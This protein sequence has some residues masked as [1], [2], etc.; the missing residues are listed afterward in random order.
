M[1][2]AWLGS[3][4]MAEVGEA[5]SVVSE[6]CIQELLEVFSRGAYKARNAL[7]RRNEVIHK[8]CI[9][10]IARDYDVEV[11]D[12]KSGQLCGHYPSE[13]IVIERH[14]TFA[15]TTSSATRGRGHPV[16]D[17]AKLK[18]LIST[19]RYA[20]CRLRFVMPVILFE[21]K[22]VCRSATLSTMAEMY[23]RAGMDWFTVQCIRIQVETQHHHH[24]YHQVVVEEVVRT[25]AGQVSFS[26]LLLLITIDLWQWPWAGGQGGSTNTRFSCILRE[27]MT[28]VRGQ[29]VQLLKA[30][31]VDLICDLMVEKKKSKYGLLVASSEKVDKWARYCDFQIASM[32]YPGCEFFREYKDKDFSPVGL[33]FDWKQSMIDADLLLPEPLQR[34]TQIPFRTYQEWDLVQITLNYLKLFL[35]YLQHGKGGLLIHC[36]SGWDRTPL[37]ISLLRL[38]LWAD[39]KAHCS[40]SPKEILYFTLAYDWFAFGTPQSRGSPSTNGGGLYT[41]ASVPCQ[42]TFSAHDCSSHSTDLGLVQATLFSSVPRSQSYSSPLPPSTMRRQ[43]LL[44]VRTLFQKAYRTAIPELQPAQGA[45]AF[46]TGLLSRLPLF[47]SS[48]SIQQPT[49]AKQREGALTETDVQKVGSRERLGIMDEEHERMMYPFRQIFADATNK[50]STDEAHMLYYTYGKKYPPAGRDTVPMVLDLFR[51]LEK[52]GLLSPDARGMAFLREMLIGI[53]RVDIARDCERHRQLL[54][55]KRIEPVYSKHLANKPARK[56]KQRKQRRLT[57]YYALNKKIKTTILDYFH[58]ERDRQPPSQQRNV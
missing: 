44:A 10:L 14:K 41:P 7:D 50:L 17:T 36:I 54:K 58:V 3:L 33:H 6:G 30:T 5:D 15:R 4:V 13:L 2:S 19:A 55:A 16:N 21:N 37:F 23:G 24:R 49:L 56:L 51:S 53:N 57:A 29:D 34:M 32:P 43:K 12:N 47:G 35:A 52:R 46:A 22:N 39:G 42:R 27:L 18:E 26:L 8:R 9:H 1:S 31:G 11:I 38:S 45:M 25:G 48:S 28:R 40:L 20:R